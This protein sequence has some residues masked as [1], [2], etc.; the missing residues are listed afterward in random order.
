[1]TQLKPADIQQA[2]KLVL[3]SPSQLVAVQMPEKK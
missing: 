1:V 3:S 2:A